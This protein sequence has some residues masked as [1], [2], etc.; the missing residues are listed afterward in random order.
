MARCAGLILRSLN[1]GNCQTNAN[2]SVFALTRE[3]SI[4]A[5]L[6]PLNESS[7][8]VDLEFL[9]ATEAAFLVEMVED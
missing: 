2:S 1:R 9:P 6:T 7:G 3:V 4:R 8:T 5:E